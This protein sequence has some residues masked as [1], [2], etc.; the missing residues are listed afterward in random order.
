MR[1]KPVAAE[2]GILPHELKGFLW[3]DRGGETRAVVV[4]VLILLPRM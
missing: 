4:L 1:V 2:V 3:T